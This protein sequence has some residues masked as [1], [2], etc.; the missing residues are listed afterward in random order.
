MLIC[1][2]RCWRWEVLTRLS[3]GECHAAMYDCIA[4]LVFTCKPHKKFPYYRR[5]TTLDPLPTRVA[6][7]GYEVSPCLTKCCISLLSLNMAF[8]NSS[9]LHGSF[10]IVFACVYTFLTPCACHFSIF[11]SFAYVLY[12]LYFCNNNIKLFFWASLVHKS[13][14]FR[15]EFLVDLWYECHKCHTHTLQ[16]VRCMTIAYK[17]LALHVHVASTFTHS[18]TTMFCVLDIFSTS[19]RGL[20]GLSK[21]CKKFLVMY[22]KVPLLATC[23]VNKI[24]IQYMKTNKAW[25][26]KSTIH[27][28]ADV[29]DVLA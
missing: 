21:P 26:T 27:H 9:C 4:T 1:S 2:R 16:R 15:L 10:Y 7:C 25:L 24:I 8:C 28:I 11:F 3:R 17:T 12:S 19:V 14:H 5:A 13:C 22:F 29:V 23:Y 6:T 20:W 18:F